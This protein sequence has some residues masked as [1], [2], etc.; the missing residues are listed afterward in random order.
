MN[1]EKQGEEERN[2]VNTFNPDFDPVTGKYIYK[3]IIIPTSFASKDP[4]A[5]A[6]FCNDLKQL[7]VALTRPR[8]RIIIYDE[9]TSKRKYIEKYW[10]ELGLVEIIT[11]EDL[12]KADSQQAAETKDLQTFQA[13]IKGTSPTEWKKQGLRMFKNKY[14]EQAYKCFEKSG[15]HDLKRR[16]E[17][18]MLAEKASSRLSK[19]KNEQIFLEEK[20]QQYANL[21]ARERKL[22]QKELKLEEATCYEEFEKAALIFEEIKLEKQAGQCYFSAGK[23]EK[24]FEIYHRAGWTR[25]AGEAC[26]MLKQYDKAA[27]LFYQ[28]KDYMR[29]IESYEKCKNYEAILGVLSEYKDL[30][31]KDKEEFAH[32]YVPLALS[33][34]VDKVEFQGESEENKNGDEIKE[35]DSDEEEEKEEAGKSL[36]LNTKESPNME[37]SKTG[38]DK[39]DR[40]SEMSFEV[41]EKPSQ[42]ASSKKD[43]AEISFTEP[44]DRKSTRLN[45]SH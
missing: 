31:A 22:K 1:L 18:Y 45:S 14:Y 34:L 39:K 20:V 37:P 4:S 25:E 44:K 9:N 40:I 33:G 43:I 29:A 35:A 36:Q 23:Y 12:E 42:E 41:I 15:D 13:I 6:Q 16:C 3:K 28:G 30:P 26:F 19:V 21:S 17:G 7:Y 38:S 27:E 10:K 8:N 32:K 5:Y 24:A 11:K 2:A